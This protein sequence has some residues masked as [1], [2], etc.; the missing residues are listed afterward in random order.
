MSIME[1]DAMVGVGVEVH[2]VVLN[3]GK[4]QFVNQGEGVLE[5]DVVIGSTV[6]NQEADRVLQGRHVCYG[7]VAV[8]PW[9]MLWRVHVAFGVN[10]VCCPVSTARTEAD[11]RCNAP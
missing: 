9:V 7:G 2:I 6:D 8:A 1:V 10:G 11:V 3:V 4:V 5:M